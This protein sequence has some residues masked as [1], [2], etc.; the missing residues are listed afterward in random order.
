MDSLLFLYEVARD[1]DRLEHLDGLMRTVRDGPMKGVSRSGKRAWKCIDC[2]QNMM[3][4]VQR[5]RGRCNACGIFLSVNKRVRD[6]EFIIRAISRR[7]AMHGA[8]ERRED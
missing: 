7:P 3:V 2:H 8:G 5:R 4:S 1:T 6:I